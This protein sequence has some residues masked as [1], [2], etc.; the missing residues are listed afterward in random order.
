MGLATY[1]AQVSRGCISTKYRR[2]ASAEVASGKVRKVIRNADGQSRV[3]HRGRQGRG[4]LLPHHST[5]PVFHRSTIPR[6]LRRGRG[7]DDAKQSQ[8]SGDPSRQTKPILLAGP[9]RNRERLCKTKPIR[10]VRALAFLCGMGRPAYV[11][12]HRGGP[13]TGHVE[14]SAVETPACGRGAPLRPRQPPRLRSG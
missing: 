6:P 2:R 10:R 4:A 11:P 9:A 7:L 14:R 13:S 3:A 12:E 5:I 1:S 8:F